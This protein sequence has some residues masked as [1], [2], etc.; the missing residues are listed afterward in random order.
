MANHPCP[1]CGASIGRA[2]IACKEDWERLPSNLRRDINRAQ[3]RVRQARA[4]ADNP[5]ALDAETRA[6]KKAI[7]ASRAWFTTNPRTP[8]MLP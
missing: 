6:L 1:A 2:S 8:G 7:A 5:T 4:N 3:Q